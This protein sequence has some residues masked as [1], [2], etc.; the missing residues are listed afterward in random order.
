MEFLIT[1]IIVFAGLY[2]SFKSLKKSAKG[3]CSCSEK[4]CGQCPSKKN[5]Q[6]RKNN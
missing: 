3:G 4:E 6:L 2:L 5:I 1:A